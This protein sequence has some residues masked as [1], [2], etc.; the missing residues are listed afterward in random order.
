[1]AKPLV[2]LVGRPNVGKSSIFNKITGKRIAIVE[3]TPGVTR[4]R[5]Y[6]DAFWKN[7]DFTVIDTGGL[8]MESEEVLL[9]QMRYQAAIAVDTADVIIFVVDARQGI[10][11]DDYEVAQFLR[12]SK[13]PVLL[14]VNKVD[15]ISYE[16]HKYEFYELGFG[17]PYPTSAT[18]GMGL[19]DL[20]DEVV[21]HF[22]DADAQQ[23]EGSNIKIAA[24]GKP[25]AG[26]SSLVN[27]IIGD[28]RVI[29]SDIPGT[30]RDAIDTPFTRDGREY[31][32]IDTAG[33]RRKSKIDDESLERYSVIRALG[34]IRRSDVAVLVIDANEGVSE[35]DA[36]IAGYVDEMGKPS[37]IVVNKWDLIDKETGT[38]EKF[39]QRVYSSLY[40][41]HYAPMV[42]ISC[43]TGQRIDR[44]LQLSAE[45]Y[46]KSRFRI[47][48]GI[49]NEVTTNAVAA[50]SP[51]SVKGRKLNIL[52]ATQ[53]SSAPPNFVIFCNDAEL[54]A[55]QYLKYLEN[56][57]RKTFDL[58][59]TPIKLTLKTRS[60][61]E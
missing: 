38:L 44:V 50:V 53:A 49:L 30:T 5:L 37:V 56:Y 35:Q 28:E 18:Q 2:A 43:K 15:H 58:S 61:K 8:D 11:P 4:D 29:V 32:L 34:A 1:M 16:D 57:Y 13:K 6:A 60:R 23:E 46:E 19:G 54:M 9:S 26:K 45:V 47:S 3:D 21:A 22:P 36:K 12:K 10:I 24:V 55:P 27:A 7:R 33:I 48:T 25:N 20:L 41:I 40:F 59:G 42:F 31:T 52:Y 17:E 39:S 14:A 51:P